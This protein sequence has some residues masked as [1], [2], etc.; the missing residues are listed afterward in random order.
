MR[1]QYMPLL[2]SGAPLTATGTGTTL[3]L[4]I[5]SNVFK[6]SVAGV[7]QVGNMGSFAPLDAVIDVSGVT[8]TT[9]QAVFT[10]N[11]S[12][13]NATFVPIGTTTVTAA[14]GYRI[15]FTP[16]KRYVRLDSTL[17]GTAPSFVVD[18]YVG[19]REF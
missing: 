19:T 6:N 7:D 10:L 18:A 13:D 4:L 3:D 2:P 1:D 11:Q 17:T 8:G 14:G 12:D 15:A 9:P 5:G 16:T